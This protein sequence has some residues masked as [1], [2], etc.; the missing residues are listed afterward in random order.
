VN[1]RSRSV[2]GQPASIEQGLRA[3][4]GTHKPDE[5]MI[6]GHFFDPEARLESLR[7][8]AG[9]RERLG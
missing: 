1:D 7:I 6:S 9:V 5:L 4:I 8:T 2:I 3:F